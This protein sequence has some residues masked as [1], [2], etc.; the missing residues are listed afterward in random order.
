M[1]LEEL[2]EALENE[3]EKML[4]EIAGISADDL[5]DRTVLPGW[6]VKDL[7]SH[8]NAWE[9]ELVKLLW[10]LRQG[11]RT[12]TEQISDSS[13]DERNEA[14]RQLY[15][16]RP[17]LAVLGDYEAVRKQTIRRLQEFTDQELSDP[18]TFTSLKGVPLWKWVAEDSFEHE[19]E[20][21][22]QIA[23]W[24]EARKV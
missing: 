8:I 1:N 16:D 6:S 5:L 10:S 2:L 3:R 21:R 22:Q 4:D 12:N 17:I 23:R 14:W 18:K 11:K 9:A 24:K 20:H 15:Q 19:A 7:L 13:I